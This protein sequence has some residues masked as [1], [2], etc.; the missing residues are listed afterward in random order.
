MTGD[1]PASGV[2]D[3]LRLAWPAV[4]SYLLNNSYRINDQFWIQGLGEE[5]Q[6]GIA[7]VIFVTILNFAA[8]FLA[9]GGTLALVARA[10]GAGDVARRDAAI[11]HALLVALAI[12]VAFA[13][14]GRLLTPPMVALLGLEG[15]TAAYAEAFLGNLYLFGAGLV[16]AP[17]IEHALIGMGNTLLPALLQVLSVA[18]NY[19]L[20]PILIYGSEAALR[21][22][23]PGA[24][25]ADRVADLFGIEG[26]GMAGAA[27]ATAISR[28]ITVVLGLI[29]LRQLF[30]VRILPRAAS[31]PD[32]AMLG[33]IVDIGA[34]VALSIVA[35]A[36]VYFAL[37][38]LVMVPL[39][40]AALAGLG[41]G[42]AVFEG[43]SFPCF[44]GLAM[45]AA[46]LVGRSLGAGD[47]EQAL[48]AVRV[49]RRMATAWGLIVFALFFSLAG[50]VAPSFS[51]DPGVVREIVSYVRVIAF[52]QL[53]VAH[54]AVNEK[55]LLGAGYTR[56]PMWVS[57]SGNL[58]RIPLAWLF[59]LGFGLGTAGVW[60][61]INATTVYKALLQRRLVQR[62]RW[63]H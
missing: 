27:L 17:V 31:R 32:L 3:L 15:A 9:V 6:A 59:A 62:G 57:M 8:I 41:I 40:E 47:T 26:Q 34:P 16:F 22:G 60:W 37:I 28:A 63:L 5:A 14:L 1:A 2:R 18:L 58:A 25:A 36:A 53:F 50:L 42:F 21:T 46:S 55:I 19:F 12:A 44:L 23:H 20:N 39:G 4:F 11:R 38:R 52:S 35:Y 49:A 10:T 33:K 13:T 56:A 30:G 24:A 7:G 43:V 51:Q 48:R 45:A 61:A 29:A 54:E